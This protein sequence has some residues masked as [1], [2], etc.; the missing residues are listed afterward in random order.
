MATPFQ[1]AKTAEF[2]GS[3]EKRAVFLVVDADEEDGR[4]GVEPPIR[5]L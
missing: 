3:H 1:I 2:Q 5:S 4:L